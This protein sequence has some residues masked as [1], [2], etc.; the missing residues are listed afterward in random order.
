MPEKCGCWRPKFVELQVELVIPRRVN[1][2][3]R[4]PVRIVVQNRSNVAVDLILRGRTPTF[5]LVVSDSS[6]AVIWRRL[7]NAIIPAI[8]HVRRLAADSAFELTDSWVPALDPGTYSA[9][10]DLLLE[11]ST[12]SSE[13]VEFEVKDRP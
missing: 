3:E 7:E 12:L 4:S 11:D 8:I 5:D 2:G 10:G 6:D 13:P 1:S 9:R